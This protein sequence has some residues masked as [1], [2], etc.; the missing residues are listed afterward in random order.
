M[1]NLVA[2]VSRKNCVLV[3]KLSSSRTVLVLKH[4]L[5]RNLKISLR[6][7]HVLLLPRPTSNLSV[8]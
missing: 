5:V 2:Q 1:K 8:N 3:T 6:E 4:I 7:E